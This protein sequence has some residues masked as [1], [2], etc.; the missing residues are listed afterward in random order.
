M[1]TVRTTITIDDEDDG[2]YFHIPFPTECNPGGAPLT[3]CGWCDVTNTEHDIKKHPPTCPRCFKIVKA[4][5]KL[6]IP[7]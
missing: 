3:I 7:K 6:R 5:K 1:S 4:I 2:N